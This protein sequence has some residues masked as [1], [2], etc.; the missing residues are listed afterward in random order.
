MKA[1]TG[2]H[3]IKKRKK[4]Q[5]ELRRELK[6]NAPKKLDKIYVNDRVRCDDCK[7]TLSSKNFYMDS[8]SPTGF[9]RICKRC[10]I[11]RITDIDSGKFSKKL[12]TALL[13]DILNK[14]YNEK[15]WQTI[16]LKDGT[17]EAKL[18]IYMRMLSARGYA[19]KTFD[20]SDASWS[21][22]EDDENLSNAKTFSDEWGGSFTQR[23]LAV[24]ERKLASYKKD[25]P[26]SDESQRD[27]VKKICKASLNMDNLSD[28]VRE[29]N[30]SMND[31]KI[32]KDIYDTLCKS[33]ALTKSE[34]SD[35][36]STL[37]CFGQVFDYV[38]KN[39]WI[40]PYKPEKSDVYDTLIKQLSNIDRSF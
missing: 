35:A 38:E 2:L 17:P 16:K 40:D 9:C 36:S 3:E 28:Q 20:D 12:F 31:L 11:K 14:P 8:S 39:T 30:A 24:L 15:L 7:K 4:E 19:G 32:A 27:Y 26:L 13:Q 33:A 37:G 29:G 34:R 22:S 23:E 25:F 1:I 10:M 18:G 6:R 21:I 5:K